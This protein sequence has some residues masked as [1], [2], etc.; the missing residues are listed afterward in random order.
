VYLEKVMI[1]N[2][3]RLAV[4]AHLIPQLALQKVVGVA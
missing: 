4:K 3:L 2:I 1:L